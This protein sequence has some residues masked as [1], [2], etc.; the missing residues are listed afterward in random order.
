L[1]TGQWRA[2]KWI[3]C[4]KGDSLGWLKL[5]PLPLQEYW[6]SSSGGGPR[7]REGKR[8]SCRASKG[9]WRQWRWRRRRGADKGTRVLVGDES[10]ETT[11]ETEGVVRYLGERSGELARNDTSRE[12]A[13]GAEGGGH[14]VAGWDFAR[15]AATPTERNRNRMD[16]R[17][18]GEER[19]AGLGWARFRP[20]LDTYRRGRF[21]AGLGLQRGADN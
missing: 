20:C 4:V 16:C 6:Q 8:N 11:G 21:R 18:N 1:Q 13:K 3:E 15:V 19:R 10:H 7:A 2:E 14:G 17:G 9:D 5:N 12:A